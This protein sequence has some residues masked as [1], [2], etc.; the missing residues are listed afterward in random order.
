MYLRLLGVGCLVA[1]TLALGAT[2]ASAD[3]LAPGSECRGQNAGA[4]EPRQEARLRC[5]INHAR[6]RVGLRALRSNSALE[7]SAEHKAGDVMR[8]GFAHTACGNSPDKWAHAYGYSSGARSWRFGENLAW[9]IGKKSTARRV[10]KAWLHSPPHRATLF[11]GSFEHLGI[12]LRRGSFA[13]SPNAGVWAL[14]LGCR[15][16]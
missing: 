5:L 10:L 1:S 12:G 3:L 13:G 8:C 16:C 2:V 6:D 14:Q 11:T 4:P 7:R 9:G 15:G